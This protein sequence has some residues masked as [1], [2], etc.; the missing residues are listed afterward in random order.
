MAT[1][2][3]ATDDGSP[4]FFEHRSWGWSDAAALLVWT[5]AIVAFFWDAVSLA[6]S[7]FLLRH[8]RDQLSVSGFLRRGATGRAVLALVPGALLRAAAI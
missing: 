6:R 5:V 4:G 2:E 3:S 7:A 8:H 1:E